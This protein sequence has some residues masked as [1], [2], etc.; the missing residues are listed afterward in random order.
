MDIDTHFQ[1]RRPK[2]LLCQFGQNPLPDY[3]AEDT[4]HHIGDTLLDGLEK[5]LSNMSLMPDIRLQSFIQSILARCVAKSS[6]NIVKVSSIVNHNHF[7][8]FTYMKMPR[9]VKVCKP[10]S[11]EISKSIYVKDK[12]TVINTCMD[13][14]M[15]TDSDHGK[16][17]TYRVLSKVVDDREI[18]VLK[19]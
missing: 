18:A 16:E 9:R 14:T 5:M 10:A 8:T 2:Y 7:G 1:F 17:M 15:E 12:A 4:L 13:S 6:D 3:I 11:I 19:E